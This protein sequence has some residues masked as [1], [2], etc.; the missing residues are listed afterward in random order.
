MLW[1]IW[2]FVAAGLYE[3]ERRLV[4]LYFPISALL[5]VG[6][7][8]FGYFVMVPYA[9]YYLASTTLGRIEYYPEIGKYFTFL[10]GLS[11]ALGVVFQLPIVMFALTR[12]GLVEPKQYT[13]YRGHFIVGALIVAAILTPPDPIT[14]MM[15]AVPMAGLYELGIVVAR[16]AHKQRQRA[17]PA[18]LV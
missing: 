2:Q 14:Q 4:G 12:L 11:L 16:V 13:K 10:K 8:V 5:F 17:M 3:H 18:E 6:G 7:I 15:M 9:Q 1:Q